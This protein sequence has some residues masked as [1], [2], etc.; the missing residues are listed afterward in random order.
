MK[1]Y[2]S[3]ILIYFTLSPVVGQVA[4]STKVKKEFSFDD[5][6]TGGNFGLQFGT[7]TLIDVSPLIGYKITDRY[8]M[9]IGGTYTYYR[10]KRFNPAYTSNVYG[11]RLF[12][13]FI[14]WENLFAY[15]EWETLNG[16][17]NF[18]ESRFNITSLFIGG[19]YTYAVAGN[20]S[21]QV[22]GLY[23]L[24]ASVSSPYQNPILRIGFNLG[25]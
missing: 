10:D 13:K 14:I 23:N 17:W 19:G 3:V 6:Y 8:S 1:L 25:F 21:I 15:S 4:N 11:G 20:S 22:L 16:A 9:G 24:N 12:A 5:F 2:L 18:N 7:I